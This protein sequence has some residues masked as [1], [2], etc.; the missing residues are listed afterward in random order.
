M[1]DNFFRLHEKNRQL[2][3]D[4]Y[5]G[6]ARYDLPQALGTAAAGVT[7]ETPSVEAA[8]D[9]ALRH[10]LSQLPA[11]A[12]LD[13]AVVALHTEDAQEIDAAL[14]HL[15]TV[16]P[17][18]TRVV[19][20]AGPGV[21]VGVG[22]GVGQDGPAVSITL[23]SLP[24]VKGKAFFVG[25]DELRAWRA[26]AG[27]AESAG[28][29]NPE[30]EDAPIRFVGD[31][32]WELRVGVTVNEAYKDPPVFLLFGNLREP[33]L[34]QVALQGLDVTYPGTAKVGGRQGRH[35]RPLLVVYT[36]TVMKE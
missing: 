4:D 11:C 36:N 20:W 9:A 7:A 15:A 24:A 10:A 19:G 1:I 23:A 27:E 25:E 8:V 30:D 14:G 29:T 21:G 2:N 16:L 32:K 3:W 26:Q 31:K 12:S 28:P 18:E 6:K 34:A 22:V 35:G 5:F 13:L 17:G 33:A